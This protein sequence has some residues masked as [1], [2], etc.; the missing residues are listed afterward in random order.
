MCVRKWL[1]KSKHKMELNTQNSKMFQDSLKK[2]KDAPDQG[3]WE[4]KT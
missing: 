3:E 4:D 1:P 2:T